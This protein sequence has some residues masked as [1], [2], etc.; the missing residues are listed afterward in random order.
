MHYLFTFLLT[1]P[2]MEV[3]ECRNDQPFE[4][5]PLHM[6][7]NANPGQNATLLDEEDDPMETDSCGGRRVI[8][9]NQ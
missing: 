7:G 1:V 8:I 5:V 6:A 4:I 9:K 3:N 2:Q